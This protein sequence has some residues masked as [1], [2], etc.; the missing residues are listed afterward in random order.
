M[1]II[2]IDMRNLN[3]HGFDHQF[4]ER[5]ANFTFQCFGICKTNTQFFNVFW[6]CCSHP[7]ELPSVPADALRNTQP[8]MWWWSQNEKKY[9]ATIIPVVFFEYGCSLG[10]H[11]QM[12][13]IHS[14]S[15]PLDTS[16]YVFDYQRVTNNQVIVNTKIIS[17]LAYR[18]FYPLSIQVVSQ[19]NASQSH[20]F[21]HFSNLCTLLAF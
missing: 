11:T 13:I 2:G 10:L 19:W 12:N 14:K 16:F 3:I 7:T 18:I 4:L 21:C 1:I 5:T 6:L 9:G 8:V 15:C 17:L 20:R